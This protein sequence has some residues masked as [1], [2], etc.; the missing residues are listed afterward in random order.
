MGPPSDPMAVVDNQLEV[1]GIDGIRVMDA[2]AMPNLISGNTHATIVMM[3]ERGVDFIKRRWLPTNSVANRGSFAGSYTTRKPFGVTNS[4]KHYNTIRNDGGG[5]YKV[6]LSAP[7]SVQS[8]NY[9]PFGGHSQQYQQAVGQQYTNYQYQAKGNP[10]YN[11]DFNNHHGAYW[12]TVLPL[13]LIFYAYG[14]VKQVF[15]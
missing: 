12:E 7:V 2:S 6:K 9:Q 8:S 4:P 15:F 1:Y 5:R 3:A 10:G 11:H 13:Y 14:S